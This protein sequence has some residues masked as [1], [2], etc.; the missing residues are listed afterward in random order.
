MNLNLLF[1]NDIPDGVKS[2]YIK[3]KKY[4]RAEFIELKNQSRQNKGGKIEI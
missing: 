3:D 1:Y 4:T 2:V